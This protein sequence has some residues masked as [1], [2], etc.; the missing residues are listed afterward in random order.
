MREFSEED[1]KAIINRSLDDT[2]CA[3]VLFKRIT[4]NENRFESIRACLKKRES[5]GYLNIKIDDPA[6]EIRVEMISYIDRKSAI[7][8]FLNWE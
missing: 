1:L 5:Q 2:A 4:A 7:P 8:G 3:E 6:S